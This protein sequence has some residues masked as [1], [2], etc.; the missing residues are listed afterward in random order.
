MPSAVLN[1]LY[2][3]L[4]FIISWL[5]CDIVGMFI[6]TIIMALFSRCSG[7]CGDS[8]K[9]A[10]YLMNQEPRQNSTTVNR[11]DLGCYISEIVMRPTERNLQ[12]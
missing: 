10:N 9:A 8:C 11:L 7:S 6:L 5:P 12:V 3:L 4:M 1:I 2:C